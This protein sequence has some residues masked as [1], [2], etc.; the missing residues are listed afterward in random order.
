MEHLRPNGRRAK[1]A[2]S[3]VWAVLAMSFITTFFTLVDEVYISIAGYPSTMDSFMVDIFYLVLGISGILYTVVYIA[4]AVMFIMWFRRAYFNLHQLR[5]DLLYGEGWAAGG[6]FVP[7][8]NLFVPYKIM[9]ELYT[10]TNMIFSQNLETCTIRLHT[11]YLG[12]WWALWL[13]SG[14]LSQISFRM[15]LSGDIY[16]AAAGLDTFVTLLYIPLTF[17]TVNL[18]RDYSKIEETLAEI[19]ANDTYDI[20]EEATIRMESHN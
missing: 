17:I 2:V 3:M 18:I 14:I 9:K 5:G 10:K 1:N 12:W 15:A 7:I 16:G 4:S 6:W 20:S 19:A 11:D 8:M 13:I